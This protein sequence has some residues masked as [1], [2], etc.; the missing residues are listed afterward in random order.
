[1]FELNGIEYS[2]QDLQDAAIRYGMDFDSYLE[3]MKE[4]GL[5]EKLN[6]FTDTTPTGEPTEMSDIDKVKLVAKTWMLSQYP[7]VSGVMD[8]MS[9]P[10]EKSKE[11]QA[12]DELQ[13]DESNT[14][15]KEDMASIT[16]DVQLAESG[17]DERIKELETRLK[18]VPSM[19]Q[20]SADILKEIEEIKAATAESRVNPNLKKFE[21]KVDLVNTHKAE[22]EVIKIRI[23]DKYKDAHFSPIA[24]EETQEALEKHNE[25]ADIRVKDAM[26][27]VQLIEDGLEEIT[28]AEY[29]DIYSS[30]GAERG[31]FNY[32]DKEERLELDNRV[33]KQIIEN[34]SIKDFGRAVA[35]NYT[36]EEKENIINNAKYVVLDEEVEKADKIWNSASVVNFTN[37]KRS[38]EERISAMSKYDDEGLLMPFETQEE[39]D[40]YDDLVKQYNDLEA[41]QDS[42]TSMIDGAQ[43]KLKTAYAELGWN[44]AEGVFNNNFE[45]TDQ[46]EHWR[47]K[48]LKA[49]K[50]SRE[51]KTGIITD[52]V[53]TFIQEAFNVASDATL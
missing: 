38:L 10:K 22:A 16:T 19:S 43:D 12:I 4:K 35:G 44:V 29:K 20:E 25:N 23:E 31:S 1:M 41:E 49:R 36:L 15:T 39:V 13:L 9:R 8:Y 11:E 6:G 46:Y 51:Y 21:N 5:V 37:K 48:H 42:I 30:F 33:R 7:L 40:E 2:N 45:M 18:E 28:S 24:F 14:F 53:G 32:I 50:G 3:T 52:A 17:G 47:D 34:L 26:Y 27:D